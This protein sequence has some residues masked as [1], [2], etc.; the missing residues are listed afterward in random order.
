MRTRRA[1]SLR[2]WV[3]ALGL[4][5]LFVVPVSVGLGGG[6]AAA[7]GGS[8][9][10]GSALL[11][12]ALH[13]L[14]AQAH[15][16]LRENPK[17]STW[18]LLN[19]SA[20]PAARAQEASA[21]DPVDG[22]VV[23]FGGFVGTQVFNDTWT[24]ENGTWTNITATAGSPGARRSAMMTWDARDGEVI[25]FGG[26]DASNHYLNDTW[27]FVHGAWHQIPTATSPPARRSL[28]L[29][30]DGADRYVILFGGHGPQVNG[31]Y[32]FDNDTW[33]FAGGHW[34]AL[35]P[36]LSPPARAE[37]NL[38][39]DGLDHYVLLFG[40][41]D[42]A[43]APALAD[44]WSFAHGV[45]TN[46]TASAGTA[47]PGRDG[48]GIDFNASAGYVLLFGGH[49]QGTQRN[50]TWAFHRGTWNQLTP[51]TT[52]PATSGD[53]LIWDRADQYML[54][55]GGSE[56]PGSSSGSSWGWDNSTW[57]FC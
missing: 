32:V 11:Q 12:A 27:G 5:T 23:I 35:H 37:P 54:L 14:A 25:L 53:R 16:A 8:G 21:Y 50:D 1:P 34:R 13:S 30:W 9:P 47:P 43:Q 19:L 49:S 29:A 7:A 26:S 38:A 57:T 36:T 3:W 51:A 24:Y 48:A 42:D 2:A 17:A 39:W 52:P 41:Y 44:T 55:F 18:H 40:G 20:A 22:Y 46:R 10:S 15:P 56:F 28:S 33:A 31:S 4:A 45:W 6:A